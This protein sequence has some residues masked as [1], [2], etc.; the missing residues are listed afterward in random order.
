M[1]ISLVFVR[2]VKKPHKRGKNEQKT[3]SSK[4]IINDESQ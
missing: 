2:R 3:T 1:L 4:D